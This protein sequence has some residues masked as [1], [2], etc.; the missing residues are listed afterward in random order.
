MAIVNGYLYLSLPA[1]KM[2][3]KAKSCPECQY[4]SCCDLAE[5]NVRL[6]ARGEISAERFQAMRV[7]LEN[8]CPIASTYE[9]WL[10]ENM[11]DLP[12]VTLGGFRLS[13]S[14]R[15]LVVE[16]LLRRSYQN[17]GCSADQG[18]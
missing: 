13:R 7:D 4:R 1:C 16:D 8:V 2:A 9:K 5:R 3:Q 10:L 11:R 18:S 14:K 17:G 6:W 15:K 12:L